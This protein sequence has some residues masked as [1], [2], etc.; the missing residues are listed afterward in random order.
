MTNNSLNSTPVVSHILLVQWGRRGG[1][2]KFLIT[3]ARQLRAL[4]LNVSISMVPKYNSSIE[5]IGVL[6]GQTHLIDVKKGWDLFSPKKYIENRREFKKFVREI[7]PDLIVFV[8]PHPWDS[9]LRIDK[10]TVR[11]LH[12]FKRHPGDGMWPQNF[13]IRKR[14]HSDSQVVALSSYITNSL[15]RENI[16]VIKS[17]HPVFQFKSSDTNKVREIDVLVIG[18]MRFYKGTDRLL[19]IWPKVLS[20]FPEARLHIAGE[21]RIDSQLREL[22]NVT[23]ENK[24]LTEARISD[25]LHMSKCALFP[26]REASQSGLVPSASVAGARVVVTPVGGLIE[27]AKIFGGLVSDSQSAESLASAILTILTEPIEM[28]ATAYDYYNWHLAKTLCKLTL[29]SKG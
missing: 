13:S 4:N 20:R 24:W 7:A 15:E 18:R 5:D 9:R 26:Y 1:G 19:Q 6:R 11:I 2:P 21:G 17:Y 29:N 27:Q 10:P 28:D 16:N 3:L 23:I 25:L 12:D 22:Q 8:M 14:A